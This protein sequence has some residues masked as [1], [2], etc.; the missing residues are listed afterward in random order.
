MWTQFESSSPG[1][2]QLVAKLGI[3]SPYQLASWGDFRAEDGWETLRLV[4]PTKTACIQV[5]VRRFGPFAVAWS[6]GGLVGHTTSDALNDLRQV[7]LN[8]VKSSFLYARLSDSRPFSAD[9]A[10]M[11]TSSGWNMCR[12]RISAEKTLIVNLPA[13]SNQLSESYS[14]NWSR[15]LRR[16]QKREISTELWSHPN[17]RE[18]SKLY[19][20]VIDL[21]KSMRIDWRLDSAR[22]ESFLDHFAD[23]IVFVRATDEDGSTIAYRA[24]V[25]Q[26][27]FAFDILAATSPAGRKCYASHVV[28]HR[29]LTELVSL[30]CER[31]DFGGIDFEK[32]RGVYDFKH[33]TG[34]L[35][36]RYLGEYHFARPKLVA[37]LIT[38]LFVSRSR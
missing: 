15:N 28:T 33:G 38:K 7:L 27:P 5:L 31:F 18:V 32:N 4:N 30:K 25:V 16:G 22:V 9:F 3:T 1:W 24:A 37:P 35:E 19:Q 23:S 11:Y 34:G 36:H 8:A 14:A 29:L 10:S 17:S 13:D 12:D 26:G 21:K 20:S 2:N 6:P